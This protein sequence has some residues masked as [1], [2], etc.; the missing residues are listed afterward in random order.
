MIILC[1][2]LTDNENLVNRVNQHI[3]RIKST[4]KQ[5]INNKH[6]QNIKVT[7]IIKIIYRRMKSKEQKVIF[8]LRVIRILM[9]LT[10]CRLGL[11]LWGV[12]MICSKS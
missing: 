10:V 5:V 2:D 12:S 9:L 7:F 4:C 8:I 1:L 6:I 3:Q 11:L